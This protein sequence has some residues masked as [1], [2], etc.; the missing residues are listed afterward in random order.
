[1]R[2][3]GQTHACEAKISF[4]RLS[5]SEH[6]GRGFGGRVGRIPRPLQYERNRAQRRRFQEALRR[7]FARLYRNKTGFAM[8]QAK[9][10]AFLWRSSAWRIRGTSDI[11]QNVCA[12]AAL[13]WKSR[14]GDGARLL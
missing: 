6:H 9:R 13:G 1:M 7:D 8:G 11:A 10:H 2:K 12:A 3:A 14:A 5:I 4:L